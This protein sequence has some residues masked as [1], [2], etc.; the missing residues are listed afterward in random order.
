M[1]NK[2]STQ[3]RFC[4]YVVISK[5]RTGRIYIHG[6]FNRKGLKEYEKIKCESPFKNTLNEKVI[7]TTLD[8]R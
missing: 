3:K 1:N 2:E 6:I 7:E 5:R 4:V 8:F